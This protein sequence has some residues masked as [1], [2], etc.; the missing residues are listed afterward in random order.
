MT[1]PFEHLQ[2]NFIELSKSMGYRQVLV[3]R[4]QES[5]WTEAFPEAQTTT[6]IVT[7][8]LI[9]DIIPR[10]DLPCTTY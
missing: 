5:H 9:E 2:I 4:D 10:F 8:C 7:R 3:W 1:L 6:N